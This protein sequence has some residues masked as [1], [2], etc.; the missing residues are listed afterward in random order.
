MGTPRGDRTFIFTDPYEVEMLAKRLANVDS[1]KKSWLIAELVANV[2]FAPTTLNKEY[3]KFLAALLETEPTFVDRDQQGSAI[4]IPLGAKLGF[5]IMKVGGELGAKLTPEAEATVGYMSAR[6]QVRGGRSFV[7][8][9]YPR[10]LFPDP[11]LAD[12]LWDVIVAVWQWVSERHP[13]D[14]NAGVGASIGPGLGADMATQTARVRIPAGASATNKEVRLTSFIF[15]EQSGPVAEKPRRPAATSGPAN[16]PHYGANGF[17]LLYPDDLRLDLPMQLELEAGAAAGAAAGLGAFKWDNEKK[18]WDPV[19]SMYDEVKE[20]VLV[21]GHDMG[22]YTL[23]PRMPSGAITFAVTD[24]GVVA[25]PNGQVRRFEMVSNALSLNTNEVVPDGTMYTVNTRPREGTAAAYGAIVEADA[26]P[27]RD[28]HQV[29]A[30]GGLLRFTVDV[31]VVDGDYLPAVVDRVEFARHGVR[32]HVARETGATAVT[33]IARRLAG[34]CAIACLVSARAGVA[35]SL[36]PASGSP[37]LATVGG[38]PIS[39]DD[40]GRWLGVLRARKDYETTLKTIT[41]EGRAELLDALVAE[42]AMA[43]A[44]RDEK[45]DARPEVRF[46]LDQ[47]AAQVLAQAWLEA[48]TTELMPTDDA[49]RR[50]YD[51]HQGEFMTV[52][53]VKARHILLKTRRRRRGRPRRSACGRAVRAGRQGSECRSDEQGQGRRTG[54]DSARPDGEAVRR[55]AVR[56]EGRRDQPAGDEQFRRARHP[57]RRDRRRRR[58]AVRQGAG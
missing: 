58:A 26:D 46:R 6:G 52:A 51:T 37:V 1:I 44:A 40:F 23:A 54:L 3:G 19:P 57:R 32:R 38:T 55:R 14:L 42:R 43:L 16:E 35:Q 56:A 29:Q 5:E 33:A 31:P 48:K 20:I 9:R 39:A 30:Q 18:D 49:A 53:R 13:E 8:Q 24:A 12:G 47:L 36:P 2:A 25:G 50:Y 22:L 45:L 15:D 28:G 27:S 10:D 4:K 34:A 11:S 17:H 7:S 41:P 21:D